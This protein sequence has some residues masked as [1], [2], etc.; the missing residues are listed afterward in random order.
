M[1]E[2]PALVAQS[3]FSRSILK[4]KVTQLH[5]SKGLAPS[6]LDQ[7]G[8]FLDKTFQAKRFYSNLLFYEA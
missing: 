4:E 3:P 5:A 8:G 1:K 6:H 7:A 2:K